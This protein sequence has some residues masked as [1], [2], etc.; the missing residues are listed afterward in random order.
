MKT[1]NTHPWDRLSNSIA[2]LRAKIERDFASVLNKQPHVLQ[3]ALN[4]AEALALQTGFPELVFPT[5]AQ[6]KAWKVAAWDKHEEC[7]RQTGSIQA[8]AA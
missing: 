7:V 2:A 8:C 4:E 6:E 5:L 1:T 3:L